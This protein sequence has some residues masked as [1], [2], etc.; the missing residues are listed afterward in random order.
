MTTQTTNTDTHASRVADVVTKAFSTIASKD[1]DRR[2]V[3]KILE[4]SSTDAVNAR[5]DQLVTLANFSASETWSLSDIDNGVAQALKERNGKDTSINTFANEIKRACHPNARE[6]VSSLAEL[7]VDVWEA[8]MDGGKDA[9][10][11]LRQAFTRRYH[12]LQRMIGECITSRRMLKSSVDV[13]E[14]AISLDPSKDP[15]KAFKRAKALRSAVQDLMGEFPGLE[16][17]H[18]CNEELYALVSMGVDAFKSDTS[19]KALQPK[20]EVRKPTPAPAAPATEPTTR[21]EGGDDIE[22]A[23]GVSDLLDEALR[24]WKTA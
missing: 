4:G 8:E 15:T 23:L 20:P 18:A 22:P 12:M 13:V 11:P 5:E 2:D 17:L 16:Q 24:E 10:R 6:H 21:N 7:A 14:W 1:G 19:Q 9:P 3:K